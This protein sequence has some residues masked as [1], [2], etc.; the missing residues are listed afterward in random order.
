M[1]VGTGFSKGDRVRVAAG[2]RRG[3]T[4]EVVRVMRFPR[5]PESAAMVLVRFADGGEEFQVGANLETVEA[6]AGTQER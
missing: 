5:E 6:A 3:R 2:P 1:S 4:G